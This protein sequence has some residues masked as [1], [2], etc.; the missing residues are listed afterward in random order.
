M[1]EVSA[2]DRAFL[3]KNIDNAEQL[4]ESGEC[5]DVLG[6]IFDLIE[7]R[8]YAPPTYREYNDFGRE[9]QRVYDRVF[10]NN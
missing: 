8:G 10:A 6:A 4:L 2:E 7:L 5:D 1:V 9:A 3:I